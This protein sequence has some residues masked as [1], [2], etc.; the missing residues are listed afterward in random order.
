MADLWHLWHVD[1][2]T[3]ARKYVGGFA[4]DEDALRHRRVVAAERGTHPWEY[5]INNVSPTGTVVTPIRSAKPT[6]E[7][8]ALNAEARKKALAKQREQMAKARERDA[9]REAER[10]ELA[11][12]AEDL[13]KKHKQDEADDLRKGINK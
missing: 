9:K 8:A 3:K 7:V 13:L 11:A 6:S 2:K 12:G 10:A 1:P 4:S 5:L